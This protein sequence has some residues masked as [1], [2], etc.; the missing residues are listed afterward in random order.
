MG[1][2]V[3]NYD[4]YGIPCS[5]CWLDQG[6][7]FQCYVLGGN[8]WRI[9]FFFP[10]KWGLRLGDPMSPCPFL[11][12]M[13]C[14]YSMLQ[15]RVREGGFTFHRKC[16]PLNLVQLAFVD[17]LFILCGADRGSFQIVQCVLSQI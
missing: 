6:V 4:T 13:E 12:V 9:T 2:F 16:Q 8:K 14:F 10:A 1:I 7:R 3:G 11:I 17:D 15:Q 5:I